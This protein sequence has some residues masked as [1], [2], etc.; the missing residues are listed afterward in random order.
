MIF[1]KKTRSIYCTE[2]EYQRLKNVLTLIRVYDNLGPLA[3]SEK[4]FAEQFFGKIVK[5]INKHD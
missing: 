2:S 3:F 5:G 4:D 1:M